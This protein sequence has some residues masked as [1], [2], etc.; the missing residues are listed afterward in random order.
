MYMKRQHPRAAAQ[1]ALHPRTLSLP[2]LEVPACEVRQH[3][4]KAEQV[5]LQLSRY[6]PT[7][8]IQRLHENA[9]T[10]ACEPSRKLTY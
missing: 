6:Y 9:D 4:H 5:A 2:R 7:L 3:A 1:V 10:L 8:D